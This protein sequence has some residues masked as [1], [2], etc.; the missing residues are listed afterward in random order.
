[1]NRA[2]LKDISD[3]LNLSISTVSRALKNHPDISDKTKQKVMELAELMEYEPNVMAVNL[4]KQSSNLFGVI[5]PKIANLFYESF[6]TAIEFEARKNGY[7]V[8]ILQ[9][10]NDVTTEIENLKLCK[11]NRVAGIFICINSE[12]S[13]T[14]IY[15]KYVDDGI[16]IVFFDN[17]PA[18]GSYNKIC[19]PDEESAVMAL[20]SLLDKQKKNILMVLGNE[21]LSITQKRKQAIDDYLQNKASLKKTF[22]FCGSTEEAYKKTFNQ[23][24]KANKIDAIF[25]MSDEVLIGAMQAVQ[26]LKI[27][28]PKQLSVIAISNGFIPNLYSPKITYVETSGYNLG[29]LAMQRM[30]AYLKGNT[31]PSTLLLPARLSIGESI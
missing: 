17:V 30:T 19:T 18:A 8:L 15:D 23:L 10:N 2:T 26:E 6:I 28:V 20:K 1:M 31:Q 27:K 5:V 4:R 12:E 14:K 29:M 21:K 13:S 9:S 25:C 16:P 3:K 7:N 24:S 11:I 22:L